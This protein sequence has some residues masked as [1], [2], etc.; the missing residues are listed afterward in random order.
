[1]VRFAVLCAL[2]LAVGGAAFAPRVSRAAA[3]RMSLGSASLLP[4]VDGATSADAA[5]VAAGSLWR[6]NGAVVFA[7]RRAG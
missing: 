6:A 2:S 3:P 5:S 1:M 4:V 7:V